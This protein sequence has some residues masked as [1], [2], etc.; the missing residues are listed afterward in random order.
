MLYGLFHGDLHGGNLFVMPD[1]RVALLDF[2][3][4]AR[5]N[6]FQRLAFLR[7]LVGA[8]MNDVLVQLEAFRDLGALPADADLPAIIADLGLDGPPIDPTTL[9]Q[10]EMLSEI[11]RIIKALLGYGARMPK[12]LMLFVKNMVFLDGAVASLAPDLDIIGEIG[13][14]SM[15]FAEVH[16]EQIAAELGMDPGEAYRLDLAGVKASFGLE[17]S[18]DKVTYRELQQRREVIRERLQKRAK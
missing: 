16:G 18:V 11:Q 17:D 8:S 12:E 15:H 5:M 13:K 2:G 6:D 14:V 7:L 1:G 10:E 3:I 4:T 9:T